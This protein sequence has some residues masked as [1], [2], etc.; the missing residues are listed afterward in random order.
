MRQ[1]DGR[2][3]RRLTLASC[4]HHVVPCCC[5]AAYNNII[6][7]PHRRLVSPLAPAV[8]VCYRP[9]G[10]ARSCSPA[11]G[12]LCVNGSEMKGYCVNLL[13]WIGL[14]GVYLCAAV[15]VVVSW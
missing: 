13:D 15:P 2:M 4:L 1:T 5:I 10:T 9:D 14:G 8:S 3:D 6:Y 7:I 12:V 11:C